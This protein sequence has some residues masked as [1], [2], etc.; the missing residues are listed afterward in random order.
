MVSFTSDLSKQ[1]WEAYKTVNINSLKLLAV[2]I[3]AASHVSFKLPATQFH[4]SN[5]EE[6]CLLW[7]A[8]GKTY[9]EIATIQGLGFSTVKTHLDTVRHKLQCMNLTHAAAVAFARGVFPA[10][11]L[12]TR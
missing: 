11:S 1:E 7:A 2:L 12:M 4:L 5:R 9:Q 10:Q 3:D 6:Q 8:R